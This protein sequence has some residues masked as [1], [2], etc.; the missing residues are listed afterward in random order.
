MCGGFIKGRLVAG[1]LDTSILKNVHITHLQGSTTSRKDL[2]ALPL[3]LYDSI[4]ILA[5]EEL[6]SSRNTYD[7][8]HADSKSLTCLLLIRDLLTCIRSEVNLIHNKLLHE[9]SF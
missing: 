6:E 2:E 8:M 7:M 4:L 3:E 1:G 9:V 5:D